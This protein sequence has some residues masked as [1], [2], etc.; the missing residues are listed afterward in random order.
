MALGSYV[1]FGLGIILSIEV[2]RIWITSGQLSSI[3]IVL[4]ATLLILSAL[5]FVF[6]F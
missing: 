3:A 2:M 1:R 4:S 6:K 5:W